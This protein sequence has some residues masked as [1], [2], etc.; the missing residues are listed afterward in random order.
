MNALSI[1]EKHLGN[2]LGAGEQKNLAKNIKDINQ[3]IGSLQTIDG[4]LKKALQNL[5]NFQEFSQN[6][7]CSFMG[8]NLISKEITLLLFGQTQSF[9][10]Q[11][12]ST[13][14]QEYSQEEL[15]TY[16]TQKRAE[17]SSILDWVM[18]EMEQ[19]PTQSTFSPS[20]GYGLQSGIYK[21]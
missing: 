12:F 14:S 4:A 9:F 2:A 3:A 15:E 18:E 11:D 20:M 6:L 10:I 17:I 16:L 8:E 7:E 5:Q 1:F 19:T 13:L 21:I